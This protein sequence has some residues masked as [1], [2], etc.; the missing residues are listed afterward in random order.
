MFVRGTDGALWSRYWDGA[1][2]GA[3]YSLGG[4]I[5]SDPDA[6]APGVFRLEV[7][8]RGPDGAIWQRTWSGPSWSAW[9]TLGPPK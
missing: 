3:W 1:A 9:Y 5:T 7:V 4:G 6:A 2:W 8:A